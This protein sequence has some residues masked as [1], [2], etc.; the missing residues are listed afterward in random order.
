VRR[1]SGF[2]H[3]ERV[4]VACAVAQLE[5]G[6]EFLLDAATDQGGLLRHGQEVGLLHP[7]SGYFANMKVYYTSIA[8]GAASH[9]AGTYRNEENVRRP[10]RAALT[11]LD[12]G[13]T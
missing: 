11:A 2:P 8:T 6:F 5:T 9:R 4:R 7:C 1:D 3:L 10:G 13:R 12:R